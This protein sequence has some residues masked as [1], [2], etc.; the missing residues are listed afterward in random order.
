MQ[1]KL[2]VF[3]GI[4]GCG[5]TTQ[6]QLLFDWLQSS[7]ELR[8]LQASQLVA[9]VVKTRQPGGTYLG[10]QLRQILLQP[11]DS[12]QIQPTAELLLYAADRAQHIDEMIRP[13]LAAGYLI[14]CDRFTASTLAYQGYGRGLSLSL[15]EQL[16][17]IA[18]GGVKSDLTLWLKLDVAVGLD[19]TRQRGLTDRMEQAD[20]SF[21]RRVQQGFE[22]LAQSNAH[23][24]QV[25]EAKDSQT[26]I[27]QHIQSILQAKLSQ[28]YPLPSSLSSANPKPSNF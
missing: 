12:E 18:T 11:Q 13:C 28:W 6:L 17:Q 1:G 2:I 25:I 14:L 20:L 8:S 27:A 5:K 3:E 16:N 19:R 9:G 22:D 24:T 7:A 26:A 23:T 4:E 15:I 10:A 21:H